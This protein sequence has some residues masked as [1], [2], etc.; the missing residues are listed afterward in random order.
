MRGAALITGGQ[1]GIGLACAKSLGAAGFAVAISAE[2]P[3]EDPAVAAAL[4]QLPAG[5]RYYQHD[6]RAVDAAPRV[7][8]DVA[9]ALGPIGCLISNAGA[10]SRARGDLLDVSVDSFDG[11]MDVNVKGAFF[12]AQAAARRMIADGAPPR[13]TIQFVTSVSAELVSIERGD[14]CVSKAAASMTAKLF[15][16]RLAREGIAVFEIR[17]GII[18]TD[19]T[20]GVRETYDARIAEGLVPSERWGAPE[21][22]GAVAAMLADGRA[23]FATGA[24]IPVDGG[25]SIHR[26]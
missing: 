3:P 12:L 19:M 5:A 7:I 22:V 2:I 24:A 13:R 9:A 26:L 17:P 21:D 14:Y 15:A 23:Q 25:L 8:A 16:A 4:A 1:R 18:A 11:V 10:P 20:A 6:M